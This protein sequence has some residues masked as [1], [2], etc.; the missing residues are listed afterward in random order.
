METSVRQPH[1]AETETGS[2]ISQR[3]NPVTPASAEEEQGSFFKRIH[4]VAESDQGTQ[5]IQ[6]LSEICVSTFDYDLFD[7]VCF[8]KHDGSPTGQLTVSLQT[9]S[10]L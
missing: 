3:L 2:L 4:P 1:V 10:F 9:Q 8:P 7:T 5:T 6:S